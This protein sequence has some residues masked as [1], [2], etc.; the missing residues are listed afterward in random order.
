MLRQLLYAHGAYGNDSLGRIL[1]RALNPKYVAGS[2]TPRW[3]ACDSDKA[4]LT[5]YLETLAYLRPLIEAGILVLVPRA[6]EMLPGPM[7]QVVSEDAGTHPDSV[8]CAIEWALGRAARADYERWQ[9]LES[10]Q[11]GTYSHGVTESRMFQP[12]GSVLD[13]LLAVEAGEPGDL[14][15]ESHEED[16]ALQWLVAQSVASPPGRDSSN[17]AALNRLALPGLARVGAEDVLALRGQ[18]AW[19]DYR[20]ALSRG[21]DRVR[22]ESPE[23]MARV[24]REEVQSIQRSAAR[25]SKTS[26]LVRRRAR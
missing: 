6:V 19:V 14:V 21:L 17:A 13:K 26:K 8:A 5:N 9:A 15:V 12:F 3:L 10:G 16:I 4:W 11:R 24:L 25:T 1:S 7:G 20:L 23:D 2:G 22:G 18:D